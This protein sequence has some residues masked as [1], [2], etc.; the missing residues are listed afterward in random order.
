M[1]TITSRGIPELQAWLKSLSKGVVDVATKAVANYIVGDNTHGLMQEPSYKYVNRYAGFPGLSYQSKTGKT[2]PGWASEK[3]HKYVMAAISRGE[4][5]PGQDNR[6]GNLTGSYRYAGQ[7]ARYSITND[8]PYAK[9][10]VGGQQT[11]MHK[12]IGWRTMSE[13]AK[14][15]MKGAMKYATAKV[16]EYLAKLKR[17]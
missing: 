5:K 17:R 12:L 7:G 8:V 11:R 6:T 4:I 16:K 2:V 3:Q 14:S 13:V 1:I 15:N 9:Y 10:I